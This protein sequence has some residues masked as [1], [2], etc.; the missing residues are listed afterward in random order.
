MG[1]VRLLQGDGP[2]CVTR[3][4]PQRRQRMARRARIRGMSPKR[5]EELVR[6]TALLIALKDAVGFRCEFC[7]NPRCLPLDGHEVRK[8]RERYWLDPEY[9][10]ILG[11]PH[12][13][14]AEAAYSSSTGRLEIP[15]TRSTG[16]GF[17]IVRAASKF[18][19]RALST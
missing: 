9:V 6:R 14:M 5:R 19:V 11:R 15:G 13:E 8:P 2:S 1:A 10:C 7:R 16:W 3:R 17:S 18:S 4:A 12:H